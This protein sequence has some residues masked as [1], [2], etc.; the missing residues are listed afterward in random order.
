MGAIA[1]KNKINDSLSHI[2]IAFKTLYL[3][4]LPGGFGFVIQS[5][6]SDS[7]HIVDIIDCTLDSQQ[8]DLVSVVRIFYLRVV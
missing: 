7:E 8:V 3:D 6:F 1:G 4:L 2:E 5:N